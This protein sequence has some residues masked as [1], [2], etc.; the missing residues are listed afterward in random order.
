[1]GFHMVYISGTLKT[2]VGSK[3]LKMRQSKGM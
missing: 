2:Y 1:M 3:T